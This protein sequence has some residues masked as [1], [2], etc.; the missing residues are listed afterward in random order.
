MRCLSTNSS[1]FVLKYIQHVKQQ[2]QPSGASSVME[3]LENLM[4]FYPY[5][6]I[7]KAFVVKHIF[8]AHA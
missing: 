4:R 6:I 8:P 1:Y 7:I 2:L 5:F 3:T